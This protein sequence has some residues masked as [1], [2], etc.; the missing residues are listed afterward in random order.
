M[1]ESISD[2]SAANGGASRYLLFRADQ[3]LYA[4]PTSEI[5]EVIRYPKIAA[6]PQ[7][8]PS[9]LGLANLR[10]AVIPVASLRVL[11]GKPEKA[12]DSQSRA[13]VLD[14]A[15]PVAL[16]VDK[17]EI[18]ATIRRD[19]VRSE[20]ATLA[21][22]AGERLR[23]AFHSDSRLG[24]AKILDVEALLS[25]AFTQRSERK[26][27]ASR[28]S[29]VARRE[30]SSE[31]ER[32]FFVS[33]GV[34]GQEYALALGAVSEIIALPQMMTSMPFS[35]SLVL[36]VAAYRDGLLPL[37][38]LRGLLGLALQAG[39]ETRSK[40][41]VT[42]VKGV[43]VGLVV[44][45][46][47]TILRIDPRL[48]DQ[49]PPLL[50][51]RTGGETKINAIYRGE[52][53][54]RLVSILSPELLFRDDIM[55]RISNQTARAKPLQ[56]KSAS[57]G[58]D[59]AQFVVF[60]LAGE[61]FCLP[62]EAVDEVAL[63]PE[64]TTKIPKTPKFLEGLVNLRGEVLPVIDQR[65]RF[66]LPNFQGE[67]QRRRLIVVRTGKHRAGLIVDEVAN[68][69]RFSI[70]SIEPSPELADD[71]T[72][73]IRGVINLP[74]SNRIIMVLDPEELLSRA[75]RG[76]LDKFRSTGKEET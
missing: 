33:F 56:A 20:E 13:I 74:E 28:K 32:Q 23:G 50:A 60:R 2:P 68:L 61:E 48:I 14:G 3:K 30:D 64:M 21:A 52:G 8:P 15:S 31:G 43:M 66:D 37:L 55:Q 51:A 57:D 65:K 42:A 53:G 4:L 22:E 72:R 19:Q 39:P 12:Q 40:V 45:G 35:E 69:L 62:I 47:R 38:S 71:G 9:L 49:T 54:R 44:D 70:K 73:L 26:P 17:I 24:T 10:G 58:D 6:I 46:V 59:Q 36:G 16:A 41:I 67:K 27:I 63:V 1:A 25:S 34:G 75:E 5:S 18:F 11:L 29:S 76:L 7:S